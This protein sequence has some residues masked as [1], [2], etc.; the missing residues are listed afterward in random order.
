[1]K[2]LD[3]KTGMNIIGKPVSRKDFA[4]HTGKSITT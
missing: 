1:M 3:K 2:S 4:P